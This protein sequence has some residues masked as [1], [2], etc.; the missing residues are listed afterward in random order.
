MGHVLRQPRFLCPR[1]SRGHDH[2]IGPAWKDYRE[3]ETG[4]LGRERRHD[5]AEKF[6]RV[7]GTMAV[8]LV[9]K[10]C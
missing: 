4:S 6:E 3:R 8:G 10:D 5:V 7:P 1:W 9:L 2:L